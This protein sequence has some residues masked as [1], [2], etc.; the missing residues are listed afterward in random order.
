MIHSLRLDGTV[1]HEWAAPGLDHAFDDIDDDTVLYT[2]QES[3]D[4]LLYSVSPAG[5]SEPL[6]ACAAWLKTTDLDSG[7]GWGGATCGCNSVAWDE[8]SDSYVMSLW[9][10]EAVLQIDAATGDTVW[11]AGKDGGGYAI[12]PDAIWGWEHEANLLPNGHLL[13]SSGVGNSGG[14]NNYDATAAYEYEIHPDTQSLELVWSYVAEDSWQARYKGGAHR[15]AGGNTVQ[16]Y[17]SHPGVKEIAPDGTVVWQME[18]DDS[19]WIGRSTWL[20]DL[21]A[22]VGG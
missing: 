14:H 5:R 6:W 20:D 1:V 11:Y 10:Q 22:F 16:Y 19:S 7:G 21:Y 18:F 4:D 2:A 8:P 3:N 13:L 15:L 17:G 12:D 9:S